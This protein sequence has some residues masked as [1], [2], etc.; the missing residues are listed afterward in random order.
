M[1]DLSKARDNTIP[2]TFEL[3]DGDTVDLI[4]WDFVLKKLDEELAEAFALISDNNT[5]LGRIDARIDE[6]LA[7]QGE[8]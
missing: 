4:T 2:V 8:G 6:W 3:P 7:E 5:Q 1:A